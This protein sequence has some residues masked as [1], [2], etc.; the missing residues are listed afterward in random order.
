MKSLIVTA[1]AVG[2]IFAASAAHARPDLAKLS[3]TYAATYHLQVSGGTDTSGDV[4]VIAVPASNGNKVKISIFGFL[5]TPLSQA[6]VGTFTLNSHNMIVADNVLLA[7][8]VQLPARA[9]F[10][11]THSPFTFALSNTT[12][13]I[14]MSYAMRFNT[15]RLSI[16]GTGFSGVNT[17]SVSLIGEKQ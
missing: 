15:H 4:T 12:S 8:L 1:I 17:L 10:T 9:T 7:Y 6:I 3:G 2:S 5:G 14:A 11:G 13:G 16:T